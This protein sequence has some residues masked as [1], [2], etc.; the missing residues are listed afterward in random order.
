MASNHIGYFFDLL[1]LDPESFRVFYDF[2]DAINGFVPSVEPAQ[3]IYSGVGDFQVLNQSGLLSGDSNISV[4]NVGLEFMG[5]GTHIFSYQRSGNLGSGLLFD[6]LQTG[7]LNSGYQIGLTDANKL[8]FK[9]IGANGPQVL[10]SNI[11][12]GDKNAISANL[13]VNNLVFNYF[14]FNRKAFETETFGINSNQLLFSDQWNVKGVENTL[15]NNYLYFSSNIPQNNLRRLFSGLYSEPVEIPPTSGQQIWFEQIGYEEPNV[16]PFPDSFAIGFSGFDGEFFQLLNGAFGDP[17][18][19]GEIDNAFLVS[20][21]D[22]SGVNNLPSGVYGIVYTGNTGDFSGDY[23]PFYFGQL[24][25]VNLFSGGVSQPFEGKISGAFVLF[26]PNISNCPTQPVLTVDSQPFSGQSFTL[27]PIVVEITGEFQITPG[28]TGLLINSGEVDSYG[29]S[30]L[31]YLWDDS[32]DD[33]TEILLFTGGQSTPYLRKRALFDLVKGEFSADSVRSSGNS[34]LFLNG[35]FQLESGFN[36]V[37]GPFNQTKE[38]IADYFTDSQ[39]FNTNL[40]ATPGDFALYD[41]DQ[42]QN[43]IVLESFYSGPNLVSGDS[44]NLNNKQAFLNGQKLISGVDFTYNGTNFS[45]SPQI[46]EILGYI[47]FTNK[48]TGQFNHTGFNSYNY[49]L[50]DLTFA[51]NSSIFY[52]NGVRIN[53]D[54]FVEHGRF[55][56]ISGDFPYSDSRISLLTSNDLTL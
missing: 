4:Q 37:G 20:G 36:L 46:R 28:F 51:R 16:Y 14:D 9:Y 8:F 54:L 33:N 53:N 12:L 6:S 10:S 50:D 52:L 44:Y 39:F 27:Q 35:L 32:G 38:K 21:G 30:R 45:G 5:E 11:I 2:E 26:D 48:Y 55:D 41:S 7:V 43:R 29:M 40:F 34:N 47:Y 23:F 22:F 31:S 13:G 3:S 15:L 17:V 42:Q 18:Y 56:R 25:Q 24:S 1:G 49:L 19:W